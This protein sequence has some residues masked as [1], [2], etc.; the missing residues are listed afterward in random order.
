MVGSDAN[1]GVSVA[2]TASGKQTI[3]NSA[4]NPT[5]D[6]TIDG[7]TAYTNASNQSSVIYG[8]GT[9]SVNTNGATTVSV[10]GGT[11][12]TVKD[13]NVTAL[14]PA[15]GQTAVAGT[16]KLTTVNLSG[17][18]GATPSATLTSDALTN[19]KVT[20][21]KG[22]TSTTV[23]VNNTTADHKLALTVGNDGVSASAP[24]TVADSVA[25]SVSIASEA[26]A[27][28]AIETTSIN[29]GSRS[30]L[31]V[32]APLATTI[33]M[34]NGQSVDLGDLTQAGYAKVATI[35]GSGAAGAISAT[36]GAV[37]L[38]GLT[39]STGS[40]NDTVTLKN[41]ST[42][43]QSANATSAKTLT[44]NLGAGN[45]TLKNDD[46]AMHAMVGAT[47]DGGAGTDTVVASLINV[48]TASRFT[49]FESLGLDI[50]PASANIANDT[51][52]LSGITSLNLLAN[53]GYI[54]T[55]QNV[56]LAQPLTVSANMGTAG[57]ATAGVT[58]LSFPAA[59]G[60]GTA[61]AYSITFNAT[62]Q[63]TY[64][65]AIAATSSSDSTPVGTVKAGTIDISGVEN[66]TIASGSSSGF[67]INSIVINDVDVR[68][69]T[70]TGSQD[71]S[72]SGLASNFGTTATAT[73]GTGVSTV[74]ATAMTGKFSFNAAN[75]VTGFAGTSI[76]GGTGNDTITL[77]TQ[78][79]VKVDGGEGDDTIITGNV[80]STLTG[81]AGN[82]TFDV[83]A[84]LSSTT[85][86]RT[87]IV[88]PAKGDI[89][90]FTAT[91]TAVF[92]STAVVVDTADALEGGVIN[93]YDL[94][95]SAAGNTNNQIKWFQLN[96]NTYLV[97][98]VS[99]STTAFGTGDQIVKLTGLVDLSKATWVDGGDY[100]TLT[101][102]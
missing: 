85:G 63:S 57:T 8:T 25:T 87:N 44:V 76:L 59:V 14:A 28:Q 38:Q 6:V 47:F 89:I 72:V 97:N 71:L 74:D 60:T 49:N 31:Y 13:V 3:L 18:N 66:I 62:G 102:G 36:V 99:S 29:S 86:V 77:S 83:S 39:I 67:T 23:T 90:K 26:S 56:T 9:Y 22:T 54:V 65:A 19:V 88:D 20:N 53:S 98:H 48:G 42:T 5:G 78:A 70:A 75:M 50:V 100:G 15:T 10:T 64:A 96:G 92:T 68:T 21:S 34:T 52:I 17:L 4:L 101:L 93:A 95:S 80:S 11:T 33:T 81:G 55:Y 58:K 35:D 46:N 24:L 37:P 1:V 43:D 41:V 94:A 7:S 61:D 51:S 27:Y 40:G 79:S 2:N 32:N 84:T 45:D 69:I 12:V 16:S 91:G 73:N 82:D 30:F